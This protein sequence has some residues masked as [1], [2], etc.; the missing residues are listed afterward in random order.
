MLSRMCGD[1]YGLH[2]PCRGEDIRLGRYT[3]CLAQFGATRANRVK[4]S[5]SD[6]EDQDLSLVDVD[7][8]AYEEAQIAA[9]IAASLADISKAPAAVAESAS[10]SRRK[11]VDVISIGSSSGPSSPR[12]AANKTADLT[13]RV[14]SAQ[15]DSATRPAGEVSMAVHTSSGFINERAELEKARLERLKRRREESG[16]TNSQTPG[17]GPSTVKSRVEVT[18]RPIKK[19]YVSHY[20]QPSS[21]KCTIQTRSPLW[22]GIAKHGTSCQRRLS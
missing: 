3:Q 22:S 21:F 9:D 8:R 10:T 14:A 16:D 4:M 6:F 11:D 5:E 15:L 20:A 17:A 13:S 2:L 7:P 18:E 19:R 1:V 12:L